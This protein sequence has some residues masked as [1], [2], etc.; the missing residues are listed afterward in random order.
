MFVCEQEN[1]FVE[2]KSVFV[3]LSIIKHIKNINFFHFFPEWVL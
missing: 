2:V 3:F 1:D